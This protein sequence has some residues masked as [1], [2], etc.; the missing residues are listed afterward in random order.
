MPQSGPV[1]NELV[2]AIA[3]DLVDADILGF[4]SMTGYANVT[5]R[6][7]RGVREKSKQPY[8]IWGGV[9]PIICPEDAIKA[10]VDA[11]CTGEG[12]MAFR[13]FF[14]LFS[15][16]RD[17]HSTR[18]F[19]FKEKGVVTKNSMRALTSCAEMELHPFPAYGGREFIFKKGKGFVQTGIGDYLDA[20]GLSYLTLWTIGCPFSCSYGT[21]ISLGARADRLST[22]ETGGYRYVA[23]ILGA[24]ERR[25]SAI[26]RDTRPG[27]M[28]PRA[29]AG[30]FQEVRHHTFARDGKGRT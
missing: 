10:D 20:W 23:E 4:S 7:I 14:E 16:G 12:E 5:S 13:E 22:L 2:D 3:E 19:W 21:W 17:F 1:S 11:I 26:D 8:I 28:K 30:A 24:E 9:H 25:S 27:A 15:Q 18:N 6:I 29:R